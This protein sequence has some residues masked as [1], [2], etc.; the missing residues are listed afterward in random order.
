M[1]PP[2]LDL[3]HKGYED[4]IR[5]LINSMHSGIKPDRSPELLALAKE[6]VERKDDIGIEEWARKLSEDVS[7]VAD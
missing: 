3:V 6:A 2:F 4:G 5:S 7:G 1:K